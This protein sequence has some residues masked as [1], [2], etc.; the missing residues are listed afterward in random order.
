MAFFPRPLKKLLCPHPCAH[1]LKDYFINHHN[2][3]QVL[4]PTIYKR[5]IKTQEEVTC[6]VIQ[7]K[8]KKSNML[9]GSFNY[10]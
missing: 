9:Y 10:Y 6:I 5:K 1:R 2:V 7:K 8:K 3:R 4:L